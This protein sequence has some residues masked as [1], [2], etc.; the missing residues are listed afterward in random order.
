MKRLYFISALLLFALGNTF[1]HAQEYTK[2]TGT[3]VSKAGDAIIGANVNVAGSDISTTTDIDGNFILMLTDPTAE[4]E[5]NSLGFKTK[6]IGADKDLSHIELSSLGLNT[7]FQLKAMYS[8]NTMKL[9]SSDAGELKSNYEFGAVFGSTLL[10]CDKISKA[11]VKFGLSF[12]IVDIATSQYEIYDNNSQEEPISD[13]EKTD[14]GISLGPVLDVSISEPITLQLSAKYNPAYSFFE[15]SNNYR[16]GD[17]SYHGFSNG[18]S[19]GAGINYRL[20]GLG[21]E[22]RMSSVKYSSDADE[23]DNSHLMQD[24]SYSYIKDLCN[25]KTKFSGLRFILSVNF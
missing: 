11:P 9:P 1:V 24:P 13:I 20:V 12:D 19:V 21:I 16:G 3:V 8:T 18:F 17:F 14:I 2:V 4:L 23:N 5:I 15:L 22:Y 10:F 7:Y 25:S 6:T